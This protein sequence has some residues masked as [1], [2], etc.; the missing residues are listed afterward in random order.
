MKEEI[1]FEIHYITEIE[2]VEQ[3]P[4]YYKVRFAD[5]TTFEIDVEYLHL[6]ENLPK[7]ELSVGDRIEIDFEGNLSRI[8]PSEVFENI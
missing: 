7:G 2:E 8:I 5:N 6:I 3:F 4:V 1:G